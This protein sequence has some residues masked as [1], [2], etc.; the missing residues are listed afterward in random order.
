MNKLPN[1]V[2]KMIFK[3][4][5]IRRKYATVSKQTLQPYLQNLKA[6][7]R[8]RYVIKNKTKEEYAVHIINTYKTSTANYVESIDNDL[9][10]F[11]EG[12]GMNAILRYEKAF[13]HSINYNHDEDYIKHLIKT[14]DKTVVMH[15]SSWVDGL[16]Q[17][18]GYIFE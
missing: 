18:K 11:L 9:A 10:K 1:D 15:F 14:L 5:K 2:K 3:D 12:Y 7:V 8:K 6:R 13:N 17:R 16:F 4:A